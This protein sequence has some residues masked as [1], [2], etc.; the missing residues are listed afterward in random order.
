M[1]CRLEKYPDVSK[2]VRHLARCLEREWV[3]SV[4]QMNRNQ[5]SRS[6]MGGFVV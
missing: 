5:K 4:C 1:L 3:G 2:G 6:V